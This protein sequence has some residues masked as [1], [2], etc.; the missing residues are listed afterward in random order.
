M[1]VKSNFG[2]Y[3]WQKIMSNSALFVSYNE[4]FYAHFDRFYSICI[5]IPA[6]FLICRKEKIWPIKWAYKN[7]TYSWK[8]ICPIGEIILE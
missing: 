7:G 8:A 3:L 2:P 6:Y 1:F 5:Q 4:I